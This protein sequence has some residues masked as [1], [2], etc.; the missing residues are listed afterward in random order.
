MTSWNV[1]L[2]RRGSVRASDFLFFSSFG[3]GE[4]DESPLPEREWIMA[5]FKCVVDICVPFTILLLFN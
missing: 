4:I 1:L 3:P 2:V 5:E